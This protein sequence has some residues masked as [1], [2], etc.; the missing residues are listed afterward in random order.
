[1]AISLSY[2]TRRRR[3]GGW[4]CKAAATAQ[5]VSLRR[6]CADTLRRCQ[7]LGVMSA[8]VG[9]DA[10]EARGGELHAAPPSTGAVGRDGATR[11][12]TSEE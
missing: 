5:L 9:G 8:A 6:L 2:I 12:N 11:T 3:G 7:L 4:G 1:L 10:A